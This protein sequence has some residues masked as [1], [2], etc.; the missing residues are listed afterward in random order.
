MIN[1]K[2]PS[3]KVR[4]GHFYLVAGSVLVLGGLVILAFRARYADWW[5]RVFRRR[6]RRESFTVGISVLYGVG[7]IVAG[8]GMVLFRAVHI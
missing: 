6:G 4:T 3:G 1:R 2:K 7:A 5:N 8:V